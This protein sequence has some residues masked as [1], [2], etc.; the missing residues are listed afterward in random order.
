MGVIRSVRNLFHWRPL[1][2]L[3][4]GLWVSWEWMWRVVDDDANWTKCEEMKPEAARRL[5]LQLGS[6]GVAT[7]CGMVAV[8]RRPR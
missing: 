4:L 2:V 5:N 6:I 1:L 3:L 8:R 7:L